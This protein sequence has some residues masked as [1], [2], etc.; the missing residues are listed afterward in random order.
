MFCENAPDLYIRSIDRLPF[1]EMRWDRLVSII[2]IC[3]ASWRSVWVQQPTLSTAAT[4]RCCLTPAW[5]S[6]LSV[7]QQKPFPD[8]PLRRETRL[9]DF[10]RE[11]NR[12]RRGW[13]LRRADVRKQSLT[14]ENAAVVF[15]DHQIGLYNGVRDIAVAELKHNVVALARAARVFKLPLVVTTTA[16]RS[17]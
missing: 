7:P 5:S 8:H 15:V 6:T 14:R 13:S 4:S 1:R 2:R 10:R 12:N 16:A 11:Q 17:T 9:G 3:N